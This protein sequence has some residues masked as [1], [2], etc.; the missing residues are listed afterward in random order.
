MA[1]YCIICDER[2]N[3]NDR[4]RECA[5]E[6]Y[7]DLK[8]MTGKADYVSEEA[9]KNDLG[10]GAFELLKEFGYIEYCTTIQGRKMY[11]I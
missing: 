6:V 9:I 7:R 8:G 1:Q 10:A 3:C 11:A 2:T 4:C 5:K